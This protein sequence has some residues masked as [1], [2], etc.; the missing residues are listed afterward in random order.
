MT[1]KLEISKAA[2]ADLAKLDRSVLHAIRQRI[3]TL[4]ENAEQVRH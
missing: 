1:Y 4:A 2:Q 3:M